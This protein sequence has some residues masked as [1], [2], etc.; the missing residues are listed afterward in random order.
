MNDCFPY[1]PPADFLMYGCDMGAT[2]DSDIYKSTH[3]TGKSMKTETEESGG[4]K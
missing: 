2:G 1:F 4:W 3:R